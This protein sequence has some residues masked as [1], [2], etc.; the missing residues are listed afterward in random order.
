MHTAMDRNSPKTTTNASGNYLT[1]NEVDTLMSRTDRDFF[2]S[3]HGGPKR[4]RTYSV[5]PSA[6]GM[7]QIKPRIL[8]A[9]ATRN[10]SF[11]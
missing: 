5:D 7:T 4:Q 9:R 8:E 1:H 11:Y 2:K 6:F 3:Q 10:D